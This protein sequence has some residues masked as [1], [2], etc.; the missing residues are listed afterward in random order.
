MAKTRET[1]RDRV[2]VG[3]ATRRGIMLAHQELAYAEAGERKA[4]STPHTATRYT[5]PVPRHP[6]PGTRAPAPA[7]RTPA[8]EP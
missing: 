7:P 2:L 1:C 4:K 5:R 3:I 8:P 6:H